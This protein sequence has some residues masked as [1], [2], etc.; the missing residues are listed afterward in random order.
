MTQKSFRVD[1]VST[2]FTAILESET[3]R[4]VRISR[5]DH[6]Q[7]PLITLDPVDHD[8]AHALQALPDDA[9]LDKAIRQAIDDG[10]IAKALESGGPVVA[11]LKP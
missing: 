8:V 9:F 10:L 6:P 2:A 4:M 5:D 3:G 11:L 7:T 1:G